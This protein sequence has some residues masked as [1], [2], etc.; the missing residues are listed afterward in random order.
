MIKLLFIGAITIDK[1][2]ALKATQKSAVGQ[3]FVDQVDSDVFNEIN[4]T[5]K[6]E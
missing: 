2:D 5:L 4:E 3:K 1:I 6:K